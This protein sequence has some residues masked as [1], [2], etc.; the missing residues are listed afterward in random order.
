V[1]ITT[2]GH[3]LEAHG[4]LEKYPAPDSRLLLLLKCPSRGLRS[5]RRVRQICVFKRRREGKEEKRREE[6]K[7]KGEGFF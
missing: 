5:V 7:G 6:E 3:L 4:L 1:H 2:R